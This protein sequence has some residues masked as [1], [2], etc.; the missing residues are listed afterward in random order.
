[1]LILTKLKC[2]FAL[3]D[4][5]FVSAG[6]NTIQTAPDWIKKLRC[7]LWWLKTSLW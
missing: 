4:E 6:G 3:G 7:S 2:R 1:M 5:V